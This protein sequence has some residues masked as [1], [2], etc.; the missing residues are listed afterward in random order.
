[1]AKQVKP[2]GISFKEFHKS[3]N[4][5]TSIKSNTKR[6]RDGSVL[7]KSLD[8][9]GYRIV[10]PKELQSSS[11]SDASFRKKLGSLTCTL[12]NDDDTLVWLNTDEIISAK[13]LSF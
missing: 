3:L 11:L 6:L 1:M 12:D 8:I 10:I 9:C 13:S 5:N 4:A 2:D 7:L